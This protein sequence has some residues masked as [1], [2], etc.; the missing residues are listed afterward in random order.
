PSTDVTSNVAYV[1]FHGRNA[2]QWW[3]GDNAS[4]YDY[5]YTAEELKPWAD[6]LVDMASDPQVSEVL[7]F[8]NNHRRGQAA[9]NAEMFIQMLAERFPDE[10][11]ARPDVSEDDT[12]TM[13]GLFE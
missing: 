8:F 2:K 6:R 5:E 10:E 4:R 13:P 9:R 7:A 3:T 1:R 11:I 12:D